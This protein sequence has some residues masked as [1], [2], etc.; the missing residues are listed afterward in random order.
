MFLLFILLFIIPYSILCYINYR[1]VAKFDS[2]T[3]FGENLVPIWNTYILARQVMT[4]PGLY[5][6]SQFLL[7][8]IGMVAM[9]VLV[10]FSAPHQQMLQRMQEFDWF[11]SL[12]KILSAVVYAYLWSRVAQALGKRRWLHFAL[13]FLSI[14]LIVTVPLMAFDKSRPIAKQE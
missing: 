7:V 4:R 9:L 11:F 14:P 6:A 3:S 8:I 2:T 1:L 12:L 10:G 5:I 13:A